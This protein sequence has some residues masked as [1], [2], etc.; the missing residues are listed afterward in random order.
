MQSYDTR[1][2]IQIVLKPFKERD[3]LDNL[4]MFLVKI[5]M[6]N[7]LFITSRSSIHELIERIIKKINFQI[8]KLPMNMHCWLD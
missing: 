5:I 1:S 7:V 2:F 8:N 4:D 3:K 6:N